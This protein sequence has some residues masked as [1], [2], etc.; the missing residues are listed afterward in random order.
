MVEP[1]AIAHAGWLYDD[2]S[3]GDPTWWIRATMYGHD[4]DL[5]ARQRYELAPLFERFD[6]LMTTAFARLDTI[7]VTA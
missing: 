5:S 2:G 7:G 6:R 1:L 4:P 3:D